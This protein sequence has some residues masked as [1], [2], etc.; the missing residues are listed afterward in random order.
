[1]FLKNLDTPFLIHCLTPI[2]EMQTFTTSYTT[3]WLP[4]HHSIWLLYWLLGVKRRVAVWVSGSSYHA[5]TFFHAQKLALVAP[6]DLS[7]ILYCPVFMLLHKF[8]PSSCYKWFVCRFECWHVG[9]SICVVSSV[10]PPLPTMMDVLSSVH[11]QWFAGPSW[12][13]TSRVYLWSCKSSLVFQNTF[14][15]ETVLG[16]SSHTAATRCLILVFP[17]P[18]LLEISRMETFSAF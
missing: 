13:L 7:L 5:R 3:K 16:G 15:N 4:D 1:M 11:W 17:C 6:K 18:V 9:P 2:K 14:L 8:H 12:L 10:Q